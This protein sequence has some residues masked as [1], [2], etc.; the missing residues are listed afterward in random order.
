[1]SDGLRTNWVRVVRAAVGRWRWECCF[2][3]PGRAGWRRRRVDAAARA[4]EGK[5]AAVGSV[6]WL[7]AAVD[8]IADERDKVRRLCWVL[9]GEEMQP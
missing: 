9:I 8:Q 2:C 5:C 4:H 1:M 3:G 6:E 7:L